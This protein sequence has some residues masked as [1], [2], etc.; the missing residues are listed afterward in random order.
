[1]Y[2]LRRPPP[3]RYN[4]PSISIG[5]HVPDSEVSL[6]NTSGA[7]FLTRQFTAAV[8][9]P[10]RADVVLRLDCRLFYSF[11]LL[12][13]SENRW[14]MDVMRNKAENLM[15]WVRSL[16]LRKCNSP[17]NISR[18]PDTMSSC[19]PRHVTGS[20][21]EEHPVNLSGAVGRKTKTKMSE[22]GGRLGI[23]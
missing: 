11:V 8:P 20:R 7:N 18:R 6:E 17:K 14:R 5:P 13:H 15:E 16:P 12:Q 21:V 22:N 19:R 10:P 1:M 3:L 2:I 23:P 4:D 9:F